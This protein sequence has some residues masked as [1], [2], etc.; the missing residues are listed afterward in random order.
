MLT[1]APPL[2][3]S[4]PSAAWHIRKVPVRF[5]G[6]RPVPVLQRQVVRVGEGADAGEV[7]QEVEVARR[8]STAAAQE[9]GSVTSRATAEAPSTARRPAAEVGVGADDAWRPRRLSRATVARPMPPPAPVTRA[10]R[11]VEALHGGDRV[12]RSAPEA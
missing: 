5:T 1:M 10:V 8:P 11:P 12:G 3:V 7:D 4:G 6:Q 2:A 9:A